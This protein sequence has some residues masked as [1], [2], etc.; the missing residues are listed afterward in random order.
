MISLKSAPQVAADLAARIRARRLL[1]GWTQAELARRAGL[2]VATFVLFERTGRISLL[3]LLKVLDVFGVMEEVDR[4]AREP[5]L[6]NGTLGDL[7]KPTRQRG[8]RKPS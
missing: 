6:S 8:R 5:D 4:I 3:R 2:K 7:M 1:R